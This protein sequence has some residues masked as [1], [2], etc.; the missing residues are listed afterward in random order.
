[1]NLNFQLSSIFVYPWKPVG[2]GTYAYVYFFLYPQLPSAS[3]S[4]LKLLW[5][6]A[7]VTSVIPDQCTCQHLSCW[8]WLLYF[9]LLIR[10]S[11]WKLLFPGFP[12]SFLFICFSYFPLTLPSYASSSNLLLS[13]LNLVVYLRLSTLFYISTPLFLKLFFSFFSDFGFEETYPF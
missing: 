10:P 11:F 3:T 6:K 2:R 13:P 7:L 5:E 1:M 9:T 8:T 4:L 12:W